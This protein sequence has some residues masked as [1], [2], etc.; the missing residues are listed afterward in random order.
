MVVGLLVPALQPRGENFLRTEAESAHPRRRAAEALH[1]LWASLF[2][3]FV[4]VRVN[5]H[6][7]ANPRLLN[8]EVFFFVSLKE[9]LSEYP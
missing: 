3:V 8:M 4:M 5:R 6:Y 9:G 2:S 1:Q 7:L